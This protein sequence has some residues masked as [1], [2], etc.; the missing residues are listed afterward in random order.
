MG[1]GIQ[2]KAFLGQPL[3]HACYPFV[4]FDA[5]YVHGRQGQNIEVVSRAVVLA[6]GCREGLGIAVGDSVAGGFRRQF[7]GI[8][9]PKVSAEQ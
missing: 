7:L 8:I 5:T 9:K 2:V 1:T 6:I 3:A 4:F